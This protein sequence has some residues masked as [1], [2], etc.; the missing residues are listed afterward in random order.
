MMGSPATWGTVPGSQQSA[1]LAAQEAGMNASAIEGF[2]NPLSLLGSIPGFS[3]SSGPAVSG[4]VGPITFG[5]FGQAG[6]SISGQ[7]QAAG[8]DWVTLAMIGA[9]AVLLL[10]IVKRAR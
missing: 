2:M 7:G 4:S 1:M 10:A 6:G 5:A 3:S 9:G 8:V